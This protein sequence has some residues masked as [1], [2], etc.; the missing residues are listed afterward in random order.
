MAESLQ[1]ALAIPYRQF[2]YRMR[3][4]EEELESIRAASLLRSL[5]TVETPQQPRSRVDGL[6]LLNFS[7][8]DYLGLA[9]SAPVMEALHEGIRRWGAGSGASRLVCGTQGPHT[10]L[11]EALA[12]F[13]KTEAALTFSSGYAA[14]L[15]TLT[16]LL[17][18]EDTVI[19]DKL[20][21]ASLI[22]G[23]R[24]SGALLRAFPHN[25]TER[26]KALLQ[27]VR[28]KA[29]AK[30]RIL[31]IT[32]S[33]FS[34]DGDRA[35]LR[36]VA[37]LAKDYGALLMVDEAHALG[38]LGPGG[39]G[40]AAELGVAPD[41]HMGTLSKAAGL[42]GGFIAGSQALIDLLINRARS[43]IYSTAPPPCIAAAAEYVVRE[44]LTGTEGEARRA[45]LQ[46]RIADFAA[47]LGGIT[48]QSAIVP[49]ILGSEKAALAAGAELM[50]AGF[51]VPAI[52]YP[53]V[54]RGA[55][56]LRITFSAS[57]R[58]E[59]VRALAKAVHALAAARENQ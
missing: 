50:S 53:T 33:V 9:A 49:V 2:F 51:L 40:L 55:A 20:C 44:I 3:T 38:V 35:P 18:K 26:L 10:G 28:A 1:A 12:A 39:R 24:L 15:G 14:A 31:V 32:E 22:D 5:R 19:V 58:G 16:A 41:I 30:S 23:A 45:T 46:Q 47:E 21:H 4:F 6:D 52:R 29:P 25:N 42:H 13:K 57:H 56:R 59:D 11:E 17:D 43:F 54:A 8:N 36:E 7:S 48:P 37:T 27:S 34:M